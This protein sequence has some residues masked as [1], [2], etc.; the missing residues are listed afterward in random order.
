MNSQHRHVVVSIELL[1]RE[2][3]SLAVPRVIW[4]TRMFMFPPTL[5]ATEKL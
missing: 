2:L 1:F 3:F 5:G 4:F